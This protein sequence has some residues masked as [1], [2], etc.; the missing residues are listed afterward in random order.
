MP[1][2]PLEQTISPGDLPS[3]PG[4]LQSTDT[5]MVSRV[6]DGGGEFK[7]PVSDLLSGSS[8]LNW[9]L[10]PVVQ[11]AYLQSGILPPPYDDVVLN[12]I[13]VTG[14]SYSAAYVAPPS[15]FLAVMGHGTF[16]DLPPTEDIYFYWK[17]MTGSG[18][19][20]ML[21]ILNTSLTTDMSLYVDP[22]FGLHAQTDLYSDWVDPAFQYGDVVLVQISA[23]GQISVKTANVTTGIL[24]T[25][26]LSTGSKVAIFAGL[27]PDT[28]TATGQLSV[29]DLGSGLL[30]DAGYN[31]PT[32]S[33]PAGLPIGAANTNIL[34]VTVPGVHNNVNYL[35]NEAALVLDA[36]NGIVAPMA[37]ESIRQPKGLGLYLVNVGPAEEHKDLS[38]LNAE[39]AS[40]GIFPKYLYIVYRGTTLPDSVDVNFASC[41]GVVL[42]TDSGLDNVVT[43]TSCSFMIV[44]P[45]NYGILWGGEWH[46]GNVNA[47]GVRLGTSLRLHCNIFVGRQIECNSSQTEIHAS[48]MGSAGIR[49]RD[50]HI[51]SPLSSDA[52]CYGKFY[53]NDGM[54]C[55]TVAFYGNC[56]WN[57]IE[58]YGC[59]LNLMS[60]HHHGGVE[61]KLDSFPQLP[62]AIVT[63]KEG[64]VFDYGYISAPSAP[65]F[66]TS[67]YAV[68]I[69]RGILCWWG[70]SSGN[71]NNFCNLGQGTI[72]SGGAVLA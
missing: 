40:K 31:S 62:Y 61:A 45:A 11:P 56:H 38:T 9:D 68:F 64:A 28:V 3:A 72:G 51:F 39:L 67:E 37:Y 10:S 43:N 55:G 22:T 50:F 30:P 71:I 60:G 58:L 49:I 21:A 33:Q 6:G 4:G 26:T 27:T 47:C 12:T 14:D 70:G 29:D 34:R 41:N 13:A 15:G 53:A 66:T 54:N 24:D 25:I 48:H 20:H 52:S 1:Q 23:T 44:G 42:M 5:V 35:V 59:R 57:S 2:I 63:L 36:A 18:D 7:V 65:P 19:A 17:P 69:E 32:T 46:L 16:T 8:I